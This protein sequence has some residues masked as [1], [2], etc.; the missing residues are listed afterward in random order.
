MW[1]HRNIFVK[2]W[3]PPPQEDTPF[4]YNLVTTWL[5]CLTPP[6]DCWDTNRTNWMWRTSTKHQLSLV[7][8]IPSRNCTWWRH[9][10]ETFSVLLAFCAGNSQVPGNS[11]HR[12]QWCGALM[13]SLICALKYGW[14]NSHEAETPSCSLWRHCNDQIKLNV[15]VCKIS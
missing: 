10:M 8:S 1:D 9:Q 4:F 12:G 6:M 13:V 2:K 3:L 5:L 15:N 14:V 7:Q 11:P